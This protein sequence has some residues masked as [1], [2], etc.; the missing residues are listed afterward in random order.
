MPALN[1]GFASLTAQSHR[2]VGN[3][4]SLYAVRFANSIQWSRSAEVMMDEPI[5][6]ITS[7]RRESFD[8]GRSIDTIF[9]DAPEASRVDPFIRQQMVSGEA[10]V[11]TEYAPADARPA[12][13]PSS[14]PFIPNH[15][16][17]TTESPNGKSHEG[18]RWPGDVPDNLLPEVVRIS[19]AAGWAKAVRHPA[20]LSDADAVLSK[21]GLYREIRAVRFEGGGLLQLWDI[22]ITFFNRKPASQ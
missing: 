19:V 6:R 16:V 11:I 17:W 13:Y 3:R 2:H 14:L 9:V 22:P 15:A 5:Q 7:I 12:S 18:A 4:W 20:A 1:R 10:E 8:D 21:D